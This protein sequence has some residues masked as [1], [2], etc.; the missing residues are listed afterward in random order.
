MDNQMT[1]PSSPRTVLSDA[2]MTGFLRKKGYHIK[3]YRLRYFKLRGKYLYYFKKEDDL[4]PRG[5]ICL[6]ETTIESGDTHKRKY[7]I[8]IKGPKLPRTYQLLAEDY[9]SWQQWLIEIQKAIDK[10]D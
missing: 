9:H 7:Q 5:C 2:S 10:K 4:R 6:N 1:T 3:A 8:D